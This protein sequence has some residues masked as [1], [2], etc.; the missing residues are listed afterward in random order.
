[1]IEDGDDRGDVLHTIKCLDRAQSFQMDVETKLHLGRHG[2]G[3]VG[4]GGIQERGNR[5]RAS[6]SLN[7]LASGSARHA[8]ARLR[9]RGAKSGKNRFRT[10]DLWNPQIDETDI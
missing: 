8:E 6:A 9:R 3:S 1:M 7:D 2:A 10:S 5:G 4:R